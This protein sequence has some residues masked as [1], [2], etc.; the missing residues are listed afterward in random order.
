[1]FVVAIL[2]PPLAMLLKGRP[3]QA[4]LCFFLMITL[5]GWPIAAIWALLVVSSANADSRTKKLEKAI[6]E[7]AEAQ[8]AAAIRIQ[9]AQAEAQ[10]K[11]RTGESVGGE[12][13]A[14]GI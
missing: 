3:F 12:G 10:A 9:Q 11:S 6:R 4:V 7:S 1:M 8:T 14:S 2:L 5:I 13:E